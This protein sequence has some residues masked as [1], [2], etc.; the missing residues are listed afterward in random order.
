MQPEVAALGPERIVGADGAVIEASRYALTG[1]VTL[2]TWYDA[3][4]LWAGLAFA[5]EDGSSIRYERT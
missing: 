2:D 5:A 3:Q 4:S 1:D